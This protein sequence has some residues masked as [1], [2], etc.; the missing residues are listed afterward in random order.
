MYGLARFA[1]FTRMPSPI[2][3]DDVWPDSARVSAGDFNEGTPCFYFDG[4]DPEQGANRRARNVGEITVTSSA[5]DFSLP[6]QDF[7]ESYSLNRD[8]VFNLFDDEP[9]TMQ[10]SAPGSSRLGGFNVE[11]PT[12]GLLSPMAVTI[13]VNIFRGGH[14]VTWTPGNG[15]FVRIFL[16][17][18]Q[19]S[20][21]CDAPDTGSL[22]IFGAALN[23]L[24]SGNVDA[25]ISRVIQRG[26]LTGGPEGA[27]ELRLISA[28]N[29]GN[30]PLSD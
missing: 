23:R 16:R 14:A 26:F 10:L 28:V 3:D 7:A 6:Y 13:G 12:P 4:S 27:V 2:N 17:A 5:Q 11:V 25:I 9:S 18:G 22:T 21:E 15:D 8:E 1:N 24:G 30:L 20:V 29:L 19:E